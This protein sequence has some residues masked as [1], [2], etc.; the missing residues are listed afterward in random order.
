MAPSPPNPLAN[1]GT[2]PLPVYTAEDVSKHKK[3]D[4]LWIVVHGDVYNV[5]EWRKKHPGGRKLLQHY[6]GHDATLAYESFH[7]DKEMVQKYMRHLK[8]GKLAEEEAKQPAIIQDF[9]KLRKELVAK[10]FFNPNWFF[11]IAHFLSI[12]AFEALGVF[13]LWYF[14]GTTW[15]PWLTAAML[16][17][18]AQAQ[19]GW[20]Q[21]D[22]G[23]LSVFKSSKWNHI[24]HLFITNA[25]KGASSFWWNYRHFQHH[26][27]PNVYLKDP[28]I[29]IP[30]VFLLGDVIPVKWGKKKWGKLPYNHQHKYFF[31]LGPPLLL[32][33]YFHIEI[34]AYWLYFRQWK[35]LFVTLF[36][37]LRFHFIFATILGGFWPSFFFYFFIRI[38]ESH[39]FV[40]A[41]QMSHIPMKIDLEQRRDWVSLQ[42]VSTCNV[43]Q[44]FLGDWFFGHLN[45]Q[46]E[47]HLFPTM[48]RHNFYA[49]APYVK[50]LCNKYG[51]KYHLKP[52]WT[53]FGDI[54]RSL[55]DSGELWKTNWDNAPDPKKLS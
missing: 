41:T 9:F 20:L 11:Y 16:V 30:Y 46:I 27:K 8:I 29:T 55:R 3:P 23:H 22:F 2:S 43:Y 26:A 38:L 5:T 32:P 54:I 37:Y 28:D 35:D 53:A 18:I 6:G 15:I 7:I 33:I 17:A 24:A 49:A 21:H 52:V 48:P 4:D 51:L 39:W 40:W 12:V 25:V 13:V 45:F 36:Y 19:A 42:L 44:S 1:G 31:M 10:G 34:V 50:Q 14:G 47:H